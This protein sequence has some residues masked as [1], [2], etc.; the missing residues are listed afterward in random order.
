MFA[1]SRALILLIFPSKKSINRANEK[2]TQTSWPFPKLIFCHQWSLL[3]WTRMIKALFGMTWHSWYC[4]IM[5]DLFAVGGPP[6]I[7]A[8]EGKRQS[9]PPTDMYLEQV[10]WGTWLGKRL[11]WSNTTPN[12]IYLHLDKTIARNCCHFHHRVVRWEECKECIG[13]RDQCNVWFIC[14]GL[15]RGP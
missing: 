11:L 7:V 6:L 12:S 5:H 9:G 14:T 13:N 1:P 3:D 15:M 2:Q 4:Q 8:F 10:G